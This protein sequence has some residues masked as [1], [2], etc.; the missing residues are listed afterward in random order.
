MPTLIFEKFTNINSG[1]AVTLADDGFLRQFPFDLS[2]LKQHWMRLDPGTTRIVIR[3]SNQVIDVQGGVLIDNAPLQVFPN[4]GNP[5]QLWQRIPTFDG[6]EKLQ[7]VS[8]RKVLDYA[9]QAA[10]NNEVA[11]IGQNTDN[12]GE[13]QQWFINRA[14]QDDFGRDI[15]TIVSAVPGNGFLLGVPP[16]SSGVGGPSRRSPI[17]AA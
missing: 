9:L 14:G 16:D 5:N 2:N 1:K 17:T 12:G 15:V 8:S 7:C 6:R 11:I 10:L 3:T 13:N 4:T